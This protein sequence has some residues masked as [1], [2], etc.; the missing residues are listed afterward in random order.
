MGKDVTSKNSL[1][2]LIRYNTKLDDPENPFG[3]VL[4][5]E[6]VLCGTL[7]TVD[8]STPEN[9]EWLQRTYLDESDTLS[10][11][12]EARKSLGFLLL[13]RVNRA[14]SGLL[15]EQMGTAA[16]FHRRI[17]AAILPDHVAFKGEKC[18][19]VLR[20]MLLNPGVD[21]RFKQRSPCQL[22]R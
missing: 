16:K 4:D 21:N 1:I 9:L 12:Q 11:L 3:A 17:G 5:G 19:V 14:R 10:R 2:E 7:M 13:A 20:W 15:L 6:L 8:V 18:T 22:T